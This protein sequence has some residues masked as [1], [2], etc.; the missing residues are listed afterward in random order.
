MLFA[1]S[2]FKVTLFF[3][4]VA[5]GEE[6]VTRQ[7]SAARSCRQIICLVTIAGYRHL[8]S[9]I[10]EKKKLLPIPFV[11]LFSIFSFSHRPHI[12]SWRF[13]VKF[14]SPYSVAISRDIANHGSDVNF[15]FKKY[16]LDLLNP[17]LMI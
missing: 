14:F 9:L 10:Q 8:C 1:G 2:C 12:I 4:D 6:A 17:R 3:L 15:W 11:V 16:M 7:K 13:S 5:R